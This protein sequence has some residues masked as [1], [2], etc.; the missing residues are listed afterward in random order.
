M[1]LARLVYYS[2]VIAGYAA[3]VAWFL[4]E[5]IGRTGAFGETMVLAITGVLV[6]A[7][8]GGS[9]NAVS[10]MS[11]GQWAQLVRRVIP[12]L[13]AGSI[14]GLIGAFVGNE[15]FRLLNLPRAFGWMIMGMGI[16]AVEGIYDR[17]SSKLRNGLIGGAL[18]GLVGGFLFDP[19][20][21]L[22][23]SGSGIAS[24]STAFVI[25]GMCIGALIGLAQVVL[26]EA[27]LTV[28]DGYRTGRQLILSGQ[29]TFLGRS[30]ALPLPFLGPSNQD[31]E[32][33]HVKISRSA[34]GRYTLEDLGTKSGTR[35]NLV[36]VNAPV[37]L[38]SG[39][40]I[41]LG[42]NRVRFN[43]RTRQRGEEAKAPAPELKVP[44]AVPPKKKSPQ[45]GG[46]SV[47][48]PPQFPLAVP[49]TPAPSNPQPPQF[50]TASP[51]Q[52]TRPFAAPTYNP[53][54]PAPSSGEPATLAVPVHRPPGL[55]PP[56]LKPPPIK[57]PP[58]KPPMAGAPPTVPQ[59]AVPSAQ[60]P[61]P[62]SPPP[63]AGGTP[64]NKPP[65][66]PPPLK[67]PPMK[68]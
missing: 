45:I 31:L 51:E 41:R 19:L 35:V 28:E 50:P 22:L 63:G 48:Q 15:L 58:V 20:Q 14:G 65:L 8:I 10:G 13:V 52:V 12:G 4:A 21:S 54:P 47:P 16:G 33:K 11:N 66:K 43:E 27:W 67:P 32:P 6:G 44:M 9:L 37:V 42:S 61:P 38:N 64:A 18:G 39:D 53:S 7:G 24:R 62:G 34:D 29:E 68:K 2:A 46:G 59:P 60:V 23:Q 36:P 1:S 40:V 49:T 57:P 56:P 26:K 17:S 3:F 30:D 5:V 55:T 25:L